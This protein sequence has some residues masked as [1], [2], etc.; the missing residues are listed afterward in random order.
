MLVERRDGEFLF[1]ALHTV[2]DMSQN[3]LGCVAGTKSWIPHGTP[4]VCHVSG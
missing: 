3:A 4:C 1:L 2:S